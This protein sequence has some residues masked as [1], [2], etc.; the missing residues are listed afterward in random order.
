MDVSENSGFSPQIIHLIGFSIIFTIHFG[1]TSIF[2]NTHISAQGPSKGGRW[3][4]WHRCWTGGIQVA[5]RYGPWRLK[6]KRMVGKMKPWWKWASRFCFNPPNS[7]QKNMRKFFLTKD[8]WWKKG[9]VFWVIFCFWKPPKKSAKKTSPDFSSASFLQWATGPEIRQWWG[10]PSRMPS[11]S[12]RVA[13]SLVLWQRWMTEGPKGSKLIRIKIV[14][15]CTGKV[16]A[17]LPRN[18]LGIYYGIEKGQKT[19][20]WPTWLVTKKNWWTWIW[21]FGPSEYYRPRHLCHDHIF[22]WKSI[23]QAASLQKIRRIGGICDFFGNVCR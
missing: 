17:N 6:P 18:Q 16:I 22:L 5:W 3:F 20:H 10:S 15:P 19:S 13:P 9:C 21:F 14:P 8:V 11:S 2:G 23:F 4:L 1:G 12:L 7:T